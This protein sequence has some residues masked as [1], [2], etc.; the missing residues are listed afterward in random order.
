[1]CRQFLATL[2]L[3][4]NGNVLLGHAI[5]A[6]V[7]APVAAFTVD[8]LTQDNAH[9]NLASGAAFTSTALPN[10]ARGL[11]AAALPKYTKSTVGALIVDGAARSEILG[12]MV[13]NQ[14]ET[15]GDSKLRG[16]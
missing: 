11:D 4:N 3:A 14:H 10:N 6:D 13:G 15:L 12:Q 9:E 5:N 2:Q 7:L 16:P 1:M 8:L